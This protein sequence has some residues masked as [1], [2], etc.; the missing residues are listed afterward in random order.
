MNDYIYVLAMVYGVSLQRYLNKL[1]TTTSQHFSRVQLLYL[2]YLLMKYIFIF[3]YLRL[4]NFFLS[5]C[6]CL[7]K[8]IVYQ[9]VT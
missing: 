8:N 4:L 9:L 6:V 7:Y 1:K 5:F 2:P 3:H